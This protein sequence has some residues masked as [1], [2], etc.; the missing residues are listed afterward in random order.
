MKKFF[1]EVKVG[2]EI[3]VGKFRNVST[4]IKDIRLLRLFIMIIGFTLSVL[5][6]AQSYL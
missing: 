1:I 4:K 2:D 5:F 3:E 6:F